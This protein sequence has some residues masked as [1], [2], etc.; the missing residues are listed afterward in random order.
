MTLRNFGL[1]FSRQDARP[2]AGI[3]SR[4][5]HAVGIS[6]VLVLVLLAAL[7]A[8]LTHAASEDQMTAQ[9]MIQGADRVS[10]PTRQL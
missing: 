6:F 4:P 5:R 7:W 1:S 9:R 10:A 8:M 2:D 3:S